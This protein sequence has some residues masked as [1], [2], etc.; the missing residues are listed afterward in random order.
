MGDHGRFNHPA[1]PW[2]GRGVFPDDVNHYKAWKKF[3]G[4]VCAVLT[5]FNADDTL[6]FP[7]IDR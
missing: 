1:T 4:Q 5:P 3:D 7:V 6:N 2:L